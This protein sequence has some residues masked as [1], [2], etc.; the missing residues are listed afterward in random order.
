MQVWFA[1]GSGQFMP[2]SAPL[3]IESRVW[4]NEELDSRNFII[5]D[6]QFVAAFCPCSNIEVR[7][8]SRI[9]R[10][11][12][13]SLVTKVPT[14]RA[15]R[16]PSRAHSLARM[17]IDQH[18]ALALRHVTD[19]IELFLSIGDFASIALWARAA[20]AVNKFQR[21]QDKA[22][23]PVAA[24][25]LPPVAAELGLDPAIEVMLDG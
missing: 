6:D 25:I 15:A 18:G 20:E 24:E 4:F 23:Q 10:D 17:L 16:L 21:E 3:S 12:G 1:G 2:S 13:R 9:A 22:C 5:P 19:Q 7:V 14:Q 8:V 11:T